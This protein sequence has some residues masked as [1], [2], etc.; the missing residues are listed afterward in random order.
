MNELLELLKKI[1]DKVDFENEKHL[2]TDHVLDSIDITSMISEIEDHFDIK[3]T[4]E[5]MANENFDSAESM[6]KMIQELQN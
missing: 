4:M 6:W 3:I 2:V 5:Y 1:N